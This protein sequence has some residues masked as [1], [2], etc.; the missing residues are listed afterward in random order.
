MRWSEKDKRVYNT[1]AK[2][3][4]SILPSDIL[5]ANTP[6]TK[7]LKAHIR[8]ETSVV[9][10]SGSF[11]K[12]SKAEATRVSKIEST[13]AA[14]KP[15]KADTINFSF[16]LFSAFRVNLGEFFLFIVISHPFRVGFSKY[17][18]ERISFMISGKQKGHR[19]VLFLLILHLQP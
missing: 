11:V 13:S 9:S 12:R 17:I 14:I 1:P 16:S 8:Y 19:S 2:T 7:R 5:I 15:D 18:C 4:D 10:E 6:L 3:D